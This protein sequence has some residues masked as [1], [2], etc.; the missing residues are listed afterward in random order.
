[1]RLVFLNYTDELE[2]GHNL[3]LET[4]HVIGMRAGLSLDGDWIDMG[5]LRGRPINGSRY[6]RIIGIS[7]NMLQ[8][9]R[10]QGKCRKRVSPTCG[11]VYN[12]PPLSA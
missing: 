5:H 8:K 1:M 7:I 6:Q 10:E 12:R 9:R 11:L 2:N 4:L 3:R